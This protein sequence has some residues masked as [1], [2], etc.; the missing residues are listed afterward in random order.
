[1]AT[2]SVTTTATQ[3]AAVKRYV[4]DLNATALGTPLTPVTWFLQW[5]NDNLNVIVAQYATT[6][7]ETKAT[8]YQKASDADKATID[9]ILAKYAS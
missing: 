6:D 3:D 4:N 2:I 5:V 9:T 8:L 7:M 1:M